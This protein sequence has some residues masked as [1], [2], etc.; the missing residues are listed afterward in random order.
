[1]QVEILRYPTKE[2]FLRCKQLALTTVGRDTY[3]PPTD[4]WKEELKIDLG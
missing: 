4:E 3:Q 2:D 1:M